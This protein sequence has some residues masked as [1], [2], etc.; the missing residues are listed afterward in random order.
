MELQIKFIG[1]WVEAIVTVPHD[2]PWQKFDHT[3]DYNQVVF[4]N[5]K[6]AME[7]NP[8]RVYQVHGGV[9]LTLKL[10]RHEHARLAKII[11][12]E[13]AGHLLAS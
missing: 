2:T 3:P 12:L 13:N 7:C 5:G 10:R 8:R 9:E 1:R 4:S 6:V 11:K